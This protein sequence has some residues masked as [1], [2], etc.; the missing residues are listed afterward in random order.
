MC[1]QAVACT[2]GRDRAEPCCGG[3]P[4][5][6]LQA[7]SSTRDG[8][9]PLCIQPRPSGSCSPSTTITCQ[10]CF[11]QTLAPRWHTDGECRASVH[12]KP[13]VQLS[14]LKAGGASRSGMA[15]FA[16]AGNELETLI[17]KVLVLELEF[18]P[19]DSWLWWVERDGW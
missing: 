2:A 4:R 10:S 11:V 17:L 6:A 15:A 1:G 14:K 7:L 9:L 19:A 5:N 8:L 13:S 12:T 16:N 3:V 18:Q